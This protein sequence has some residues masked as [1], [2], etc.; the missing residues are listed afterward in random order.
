MIW[1]LPVAGAAIGALTNKKNPLQG[2]AMGGLL[3]AGAGF[4]A[5][6]MMGGAA[7]GGASGAA[8][9][10]LL[11]AESSMPAA[12]A[13]ANTAPAASVT[14]NG[15][16]LGEGVSSGIG[17]W[18]AAQAK[19]GLLSGLKTA[20][21]YAKPVGNAMSAAN[22]AKGLLAPEQQPI[23]HQMQPQMVQGEQTLA[24]LAN[25]DNQL[26]NSMQQ[27]DMARRQNRRQLIGRIGG[28]A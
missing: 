18:D 6:A 12:A 22:S 14:G 25:Q 11:A 5:P 7:A 23:Q 19:A 1:W 27:A 24:A 16:F 28:Y 17:A 15:A 2:A 8:G 9:G 13:M 3:G 21:E 20:G 4:A 26:L 10:G